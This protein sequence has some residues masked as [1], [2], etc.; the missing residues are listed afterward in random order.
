M[1]KNHVIV[2]SGL[3]VTGSG[4]RFTEGKRDYYLISLPW[5]L[6]FF[7][8]SLFRRTG[9]CF[10]WSCFSLISF[11]VPSSIFQSLSISYQLSDLAIYFP[12]NSLIKKYPAVSPTSFLSFSL[13]LSPCFGYLFPSQFSDE[14]V[15]L[16][17]LLLSFPS[18]FISLHF[19][20]TLHLLWLYLFPSQFSDENVPL[21]LLQILSFLSLPCLSFLEGVGEAI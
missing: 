15:P 6:R 14:N 12:H 10:S 4:M 2:W 3:Q 8:G 11:S 7:P 9:G 21:F 19:L 5:V 1:K 20:P 16:F 17:L 18:P 13:H